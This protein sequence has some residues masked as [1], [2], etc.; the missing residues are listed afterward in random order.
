MTISPI[1][2]DHGATTPVDP[3][4]LEAMLPY[5][6][7]DYGNPSSFHAYGQRA[8]AVL[9]TA[10]ETVAGLIGARP[11]E[12]VF[13]GNG[14]ESDN[15][16]LRGVLGAKFLAG[17]PGHIIIS[18][19]EHSAVKT[20]AY[21]LHDLFGCDV[22]E[23]PVDHYGQIRLCDL[24]AA[25][26]P[27]TTLISV[28]AA[29]NEIGTLQPVAEIGTLARAHGIIFHTDAVQ[30]IASQRWDMSNMPID[31]LSIAPHKF[32]GPKGVGIL[33]VR[34]GIELA[35]AL[36]GGGQENQRRAGTENVAFAVGAAEALRIVTEEQ[37]ILVNRYQG[38][39]KM[40]I[41]GLLATL[42]DDCLLTGHPEQRL[43][44]NA[45]F[46][47]RGVTGNDILMH[48]DM[49]GIAA[50]SGSACKSGD[51]KPSATLEALGLDP[52]W[53]RGGLRLTVG[54]QNDE[55]QIRYTLQQIP[56]IVRRLQELNRAWA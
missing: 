20:T 34:S 4:V 32:Y 41:E 5:W 13:T 55:D 21:Q 39:S 45:S 3:R 40:L 14:S 51:P 26:R 15:L 53:T 27:D 54:R 22:T 12:I 36:T 23:L 17:R 44:H 47:F 7:A 50:S 43:P 28:M 2:L 9:E 11:D 49:V 29:N 37:S 31:L 38:L 8:A 19:I 48:L 18:S 1:Y 56:A 24:E 46:A 16:A 30:A 33:Y 35:P 25:I 6:T 42:P 10:H 52:E